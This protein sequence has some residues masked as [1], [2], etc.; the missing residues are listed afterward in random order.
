MDELVKKLKAATENL[1]V[2][3]DRK[4]FSQILKASATMDEDIRLGKLHSFEE[5][6]GEESIAGA[7]SQERRCRAP[8]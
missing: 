8:A 6:I 1:A 2:V 4:L 7:E 3:K 5:A